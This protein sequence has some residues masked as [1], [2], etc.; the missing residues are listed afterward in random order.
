M[1]EYFQGIS[2]SLLFQFVV[3]SFL[4]IIVLRIRIRIKPLY[5]ILLTLAKYGLV[6]SIFAFFDFS[7]WL[8]VDDITYFSI[9]KDLYEQGYSLFS[10]DTFDRLKYLS[11][12]IH[13]M[14]SW[15]NML[16]HSVWGG[17]YFS[18]V[19]F[20]VFLTFIC[21]VYIYDLSLRVIGVR[22]YSLGLFLFF[23]MHWDILTWSSFLNLK[24]ILV[25]FLTLTSFWLIICR[26][27]SKPISSVFVLFLVCILF[28]W[29]RF[30]VP[31]IIGIS[32]G[33]YS[34]KPNFS[35]VLKVS[36]LILL[37][38]F[39]LSYLGV[40][41]L[42]YFIA[43]LNFGFETIAGI[44]RFVITPLP[45]KIEDSYSF[46]ILSSLLHFVFFIPAIIGGTQLIYKYKE[47]YLITLFSII[48]L[49]IYGSFPELQ[50][51][52][53]RIQ[54]SFVIIWFQYHSIYS[55]LRKHYA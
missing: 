13:I 48:C 54:L 20:N 52:R 28:Y 33:I 6:F 17:Y 51:P 7:H 9:S 3:Y 35:M 42:Q 10:I 8:K 2:F 41:S 16:L 55:Y 21:G 36:G 43:K 24:D 19:Y 4:T 45:W 50:G 47:F 34:L 14:Y 46:L 11:G 53:H 1:S 37:S 38:V 12:G 31:V 40:D 32:Y 49:F 44:S 39:F 26:L 22:K 30:Y 29:T 27:P 5:I 15:V 18:T 25:L 23:C